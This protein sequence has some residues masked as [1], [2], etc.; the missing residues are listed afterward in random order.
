MTLHAAGD[1]PRVSHNLSGLTD[2]ELIAEV[3]RLAARE[4][5]ATADVIRSLIEFDERRLYLA[6][7]YPSLFAYCTAVL[8]Y[9]EHS[10]LN[11]IEVA[12]AASRWPQLLSCLEDGSLHLSGARILAPHLTDDNLDVALACARHKSKREIEEIAAKLARRPVISALAAEHFRM[13][14]TI[15]RHTREKLRQAQDLLRHVVPDG[16]PGV[17]FDRALTVLL[18][19]LERQRFAATARPRRGRHPKKGSRR[20]PSA[21]RRQV[22]KRDGGR[23][24]FV[25]TRGRCAERGFLE[26][27][28]VVP[29]AAGGAATVDNIQLRC[30]AHNAYEAELYFGA[31]RHG[32]SGSVALATTPSTEDSCGSPRGD[33]VLSADM[34][35]HDLAGTLRP[36]V[37]VSQVS[38]TG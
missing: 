12:R 28:H 26:F 35:T 25:G 6:E 24:T 8:H 32:R 10:A 38:Q 33:T 13:H 19:Q 14:L 15:S 1:T 4:R 2:A 7:G 31:G 18:E 3:A 27:H 23:C 22:W 5:A 34:T 30:R 11:R 20:I 36:E 21:V 16:D 17:I 37:D 9:S 29:F